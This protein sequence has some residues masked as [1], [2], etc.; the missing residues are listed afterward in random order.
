MAETPNHDQSSAG[1]GEQRGKLVF[2]TVGNAV[3]NGSVASP[4][5]KPHFVQQSRSLLSSQ[6]N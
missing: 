5:T 1:E 2:T 3:D 6:M 4:E